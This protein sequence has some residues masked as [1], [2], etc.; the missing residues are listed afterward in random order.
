MLARFD[1]FPTADVEVQTSF[2]GVVGL[3]V[4]PPPLPSR[5]LLF[6]DRLGAGDC[7]NT[8]EPYRPATSGTNLTFGTPPFLSCRKAGSQRN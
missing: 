3:R 8:L 6:P 5:W 1:R 4:V 7:E 2:G